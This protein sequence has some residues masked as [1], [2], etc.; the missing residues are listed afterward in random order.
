MKY[1]NTDDIIFQHMSVEEQ[2]F[3]PIK[4]RSEGVNRFRNG[5]I[6]QQLTSV[7]IEEIVTVGGGII[8]FCEGFFCVNLDYTPF[9]KFVPGMTKK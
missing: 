4:N 9:E 2:V 5:K 1:Y 3:N 6:R 7:D 8:E